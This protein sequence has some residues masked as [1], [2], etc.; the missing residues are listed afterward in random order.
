ADVL[1][2]TLVRQPKISMKFKLFKFI[3]TAIRT[4]DK[5]CRHCGTTCTTMWRR[6]DSGERLCNACKLYKIRNGINRPLRLHNKDIRKR[7]QRVRDMPYHGKQVILR[8][9]H[10]ENEQFG[11]SGMPI[12]YE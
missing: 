2:P 4:D 5:Q 9:H 6:G 8:L 11:N 3:F 1:L 12:S 7:S 10:F